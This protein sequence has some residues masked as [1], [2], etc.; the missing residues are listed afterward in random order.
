MDDPVDNVV[1]GFRNLTAGEQTRAWI[2]IEEIWKSAPKGNAWPHS[3][4]LT[5]S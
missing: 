2:E 1:E 5:A 4:S 3:P